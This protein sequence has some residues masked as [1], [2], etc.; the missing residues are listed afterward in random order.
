MTVTQIR[1]LRLDLTTVDDLLTLAQAAERLGR[2]TAEVFAMV[3]AGEL[4]SVCTPRMGLVVAAA[5]VD[6]YV[7]T[8]VPA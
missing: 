2:T 3:R 1:D 7:G 4:E 6:R 5:D 8:D